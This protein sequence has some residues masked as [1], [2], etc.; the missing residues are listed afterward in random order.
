MLR[1]V[2]VHFVSQCHHYS[3]AA[4]PI[5]YSIPLA[6]LLIFCRA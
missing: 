5:Q 3:K 4:I 2:Q 1:H 6:G